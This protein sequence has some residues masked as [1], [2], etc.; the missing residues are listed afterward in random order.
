MGL[1]LPGHPKARSQGCSSLIPSCLHFSL[2]C[3]PR[4]PEGTQLS[5]KV[6]HHLELSALEKAGR[7]AGSEG[8]GRG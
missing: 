2:A 8:L 6:A 3:L 7:G 5:L 1:I 4:Y